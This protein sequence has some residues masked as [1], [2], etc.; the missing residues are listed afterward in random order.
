MC[1]R[2]HKHTVSHTAYTRINISSVSKLA[3]GGA[4]A[5]TCLAQ[6]FGSSCRD[7]PVIR[8]RVLVT[9]PSRSPNDRSSF[10]IQAVPLFERLLRVTSATEQPTRRFAHA[11]IP[12]LVTSASAHVRSEISEISER[13]GSAHGLRTRIVPRPAGARVRCGPTQRVGAESRM[14]RQWIQVD[15]D[16]ARAVRLGSGP[17]MPRPARRPFRAAPCSMVHTLT[18]TDTDRK[19][20]RQTQTDTDMPDICLAAWPYSAWSYPDIHRHTN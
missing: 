6:R 3:G 17:W 18:Q 11:I 20:D 15:S 8:V 1:A 7:A 16:S 4:A 10:I 2:T 13:R 9:H 12:P 14:A 5:W 19:T